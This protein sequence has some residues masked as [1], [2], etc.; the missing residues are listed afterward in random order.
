[1][2]IPTPEACS[3]N[4]LREAAR[5]VTRLYDKAIAPTGLGLNQYT[6]LRKL[7]ALGP[8]A[9]QNLADHLVMDRST[10]ARLLG[11]LEKRGLVTIETSPDD[12]RSRIVELRAEGQALLREALPLWERAQTIFEE[13]YGKEEALQL[14][15]SL[16]RI[17]VSEFGRSGKSKRRRG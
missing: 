6:A 12:R 8:V 4:A 13:F 16:K 5:R 7:N 2:S 11:P 3:G 17:A 14:R 1:M 15:A 9:I 10:V